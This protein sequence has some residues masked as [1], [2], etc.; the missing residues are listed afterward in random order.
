M[1]SARICAL[2][3]S[4]A[5][6]CGAVPSTNTTGDGVIRGFIPGAGFTTVRVV[7][8]A[9]LK[10][11]DIVR[12][13]ADYSCGAAALAT[14]MTYAYGRRLTEVGA[15]DG[16]MAVSDPSVV[17]SR[18]FSLLDM[19]HYVQTIGYSGAGYHLPMASLYAVVVP[20]IVLM[21]VQGYDHFVVMKHATPES[22]EIADPM[23]GNRSVPT[24]DF[25]K[26]WNGIIFVIASPSYDKRNVLAALH[27]PLAYNRL[28]S[29]LPQTARAVAD[30]VLMSVYIPAMTRL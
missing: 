5:V 25:A 2:M 27:A 30:A 21:N 29:T 9:A 22:V 14:I 6:L 18:G 8:L 15:I 19:K 1:I 26:S 12:Q 4:V 16:M 20:V 3:A 13:H 28:S 11:K 10:F 17:R 7:S 23:L 24:P